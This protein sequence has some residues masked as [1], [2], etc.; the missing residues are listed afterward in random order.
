MK[1]SMPFLIFLVTISSVYGAKS[2]ILYL[3]GRVPASISL[4]EVSGHQNSK[5]RFTLKSNVH[6]SKYEVNK[7]IRGKLQYIEII[8]R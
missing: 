4:G 7:R 1:I 6:P 5:G 8:S 2:Q 3:S